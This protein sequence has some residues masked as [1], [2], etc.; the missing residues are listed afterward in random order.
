[1]PGCVTQ[2]SVE[3]AGSSAVASQ[4]QLTVSVSLVEFDKAPTVAVTVSVYVP[5]GVPGEPWEELEPPQEVHIT[6]A[7]MSTPRH[8]SRSR[9]VLPFRAARQSA[10]RLARVKRQTTPVPSRPM[11]VFMT[12][13]TINVPAVVVTLTVK[14]TACVPSSVTEDGE[15]EQAASKGAPLHPS[16][17]V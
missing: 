7:T 12:R 4:L 10:K 2:N 3:N 13:P 8:A 9:K 16:V 14:E 6:P 11:G 1:M 15:T 17:R 5:A